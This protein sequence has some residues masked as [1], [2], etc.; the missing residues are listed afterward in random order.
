MTTFG[1]IHVM[2]RIALIVAASKV[3]TVDTNHPVKSTDTTFL[4]IVSSY[5]GTPCLQGGLKKKMTHAKP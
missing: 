3:F 5:M 1:A 2:D 4:S